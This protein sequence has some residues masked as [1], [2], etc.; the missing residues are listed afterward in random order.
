MKPRD[1]KGKV[2]TRDVRQEEDGT[3]SVM[4]WDG[5]GT[6]ED[7]A[8]NL[9]R[10]AGFY[11]RDWA[12]AAYKDPEHL[13]NRDTIKIA[14]ALDKRVTVGDPFGDTPKSRRTRRVNLPSGLADLDKS[15][16]GSAGYRCNVCHKY[17]V[18]E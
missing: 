6:P 5:D 17:I 2:V 1:R 11:S 3:W 13:P 9:R 4:L 10:V 18:G 7:P 16:E 12:I 15:R 14:F 8:K